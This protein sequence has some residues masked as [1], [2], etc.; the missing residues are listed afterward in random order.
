M[1]VFIEYV[2]TSMLRRSII[3]GV[4]AAF[5]GSV[6]AEISIPGWIQAIAVGIGVFAAMYA[7]EKNYKIEE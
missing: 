4:A 5:A 7:I 3:V 6:L 1:K 2:F